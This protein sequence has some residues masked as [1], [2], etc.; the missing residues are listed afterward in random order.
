MASYNTKPDMI[1]Q[2]DVDWL[3]PRVGKDWLEK[4]IK[5]GQYLV[6]DEKT[7]KKSRDTGPLL[8]YPESLVSLKQKFDGDLIDDMIQRGQFIPV[9]EN[10][11]KVDRPVKS[12][13]QKSKV[14]IQIVRLITCKRCK[15]HIPVDAKYCCY[16]SQEIPQKRPSKK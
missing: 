7:L 15:K 12:W 16:C 3:I 2:D 4:K 5:A 1:T 9:D 13:K 11:N 6:V 14:V 8:I 10:G